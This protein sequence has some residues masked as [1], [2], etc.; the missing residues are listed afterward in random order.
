MKRILAFLLVFTLVI[1]LAACDV[2]MLNDCKHTFGEYHSNNDQHWRNYTCGCDIDAVYEDH[3]DENSDGKCDA[4]G[5]GMYNGMDHICS[6]E[7]YRDAEYHCLV[8]VCGCHGFPNF[9]EPHYDLDGDKIC[10]A[11]GYEMTDGEKVLLSDYESWLKIASADGIV[12][13]KTTREPG[14]NYGDLITIQR[15]TNKD[16]IA[17]MIEACKN[18]ELLPVPEYVNLDLVPGFFEI[19]FTFAGGD[20]E[21]ICFAGRSLYTDYSNRKRFTALNI[22][23]LEDCP[24]YEISY[25][26]ATYDKDSGIVYSLDENGK[27]TEYCRLDKIGK[28]EFEAYPDVCYPENEPTHLI[29]TEFGDIYVMSQKNFFITDKSGNNVWFRLINADFYQLFE[30][31]LQTDF[32]VTMNDPEWLAEE[33]QPTYKAGDTVEVKISMATDT[34]Y[35]FFVNGEKIRE[36][37]WGDGLWIFTFTMPEEDVVIDFKTYDGFLPDYRYAVLI[38]TYWIDHFEADRVWVQKYYG[39]FES[40]AIVAY[41]G[42]DCCMYTEALW[43]EKIGEYEINYF[44]GHRIEVLYEREFYTLTEAYENGWLTDENIAEITGKH[45]M[46]Y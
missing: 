3:H 28:L 22:P 1:S 11:C 16:S 37:G 25:S 33:L 5:Y 41:M 23:T 20:V 7:Y 42:C 10:D 39:E 14:W 45:N 17:Q 32:T 2:F 31:A 44:D 35:M 36:S 9:Y 19:E 21:T 24:H 8:S 4:C 26:F 43:T 30:R 40:G 29:R 34:G 13:V 27:S 18:I 15:S 46:D 6:T 38:E 12:E